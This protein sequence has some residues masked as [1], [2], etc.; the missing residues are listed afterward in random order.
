MKHI[1]SFLTIALLAT[2]MMAQTGLTCEDAIPVD[3]NYVGRVEGPGEIWYTAGTYDLPLNVHFIPDDY[4]SEDN[5]PYVMIDVTCEEGVYEDPKIDSILTMVEELGFSFPAEMMCDASQ[6]GDRME[7][8]IFIDDLYREQL[9]QFGVT[10]NVKAFVK[11]TFFEAGTI[12]LKPDTMFSSCVDPSK[13]KYIALNDTL[14]ILANDQKSVFVLPYTDWQNDSI[15]FVWTGD[16]PATVWVAADNC[17]FNP[18][19]T[20]RYVYDNYVVYKDKPYKVNNQRI[21]NTIKDNSGGGLLYAKVTS[22]SAGKLVAEIIPV[23]KPQGNATLLEYGQATSIAAND[24]SLYCFSKAWTSTQFFSASSKGITMYASAQPAFECSADDANVLAVHPFYKNNG[25]YELSLSAREMSALT[26]NASDNYIYVRFQAAEATTITSEMWAASECADKSTV[27]VS[28][29]MIAVESKSANKIYRLRYDDWK[30]GEMVITWEANVALPLYIADTCQYTLSK[31][32]KRV[33][34]YKNITASNN[35]ARFDADVVNSWESRVDADG[36]L[37]VRFNPSKA[38]DVIFVCEKQNVTE[39]IYVT[40]NETR[41]YGET[42]DFGGTICTESGTYE[43]T[44]TALNGAD[45]I[46]TLNLTILPEV[47]PTT[48]E[49]T[50]RYDALPYLWNDSAFVESTEYTATLQDAYG[51]DSVVTLKL[52]VLEKS[53]IKTTD[54]VILNLAS[55]FKVYTMDHT[56]WVA[57]DVK[58]NWEGASPLHVFVAK[59]EIY[60]LTPFNRYVLHYEVVPAGEEWV[61]TKEQMAAW[62][63]EATAAGGKLYVRF[64]TEK[65]GRLTTVPM[66]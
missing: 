5:N 26:N 17:D 54:D 66:D 61:V 35:V 33:V 62:E 36:F 41:C 38:G 31:N 4:N 11:V 44:F 60:N 6:V 59:E 20:S 1:F 42:Y 37:Y 29:E 58:V 34:Q 53:D 55:A 27:I 64:L 14:D 57:D 40:L 46:V 50:V 52:T 63:A 45:S 22:A 9:S 10:Y 12:S 3:S 7:Y 51:C 39:P 30:D 15:Q 49:V 2:S 48:D 21:N 25:L 16:E 47:L 8:D 32:N 65:D 18:S 19:T 56:D 23:P 43:K 13:S 28:G 24:T